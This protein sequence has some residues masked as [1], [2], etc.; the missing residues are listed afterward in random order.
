MI[1]HES[2]NCAIALNNMGVSMLERHCYRQAYQTFQDAVFAMK[3]ALGVSSSPLDSSTSVQLAVHQKLQEAVHRV[4][5]PQVSPISLPIDSVSD[6]TSITLIEWS[7]T[8]MNEIVLTRPIRIEVEEIPNNIISTS[9][10]IVAD[11]YTSI[12]L[13]NFGLAHLCCSKA[14]SKKSGQVLQQQLNESG[15]TLFKLSHSLLSK[16]F[17]RVH[18]CQGPSQPTNSDNDINSSLAHFHPQLFFVSA[19]LLQ[20]LALTFLQDWGMAEQA[21]LCFERLSD[22]LQVAELQSEW[23]WCDRQRVTAGAA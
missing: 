13:Y 7:P 12:L 1:R 8:N 6:V 4:S 14:S 5:N 9:V 21:K 17:E 18:S 11:L 22:L 3:A 16:S 23:M 2:T 19:I 10:S 15:L 20:T